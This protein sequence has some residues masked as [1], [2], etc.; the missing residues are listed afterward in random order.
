MILLPTLLLAFPAPALPSAVTAQARVAIVSPLEVA[1]AAVR[2]ESIRS[3]LFFLAS[4]ELEGRDTPSPGLRIAA[5]YIRTR[6]E[7]L[8]WKPGAGGSF[9]HLY[10]LEQR[11][12]DEE[13]SLIAWEAG[14]ERGL[15]RYGTDYFLPSLFDCRTM[16]ARGGVVFCGTGSP[17]DFEGLALEGRWALCF[18]VGT[19]A[20]R[21]REPARKAGAVGVLLA[22]GPGYQGEPYPKRYA[23]DLARQRRGGAAF[24]ADA[25]NRSPERQPYPTVLLDGEVLARLLA[26]AGVF[27]ETAR[28]TDVLGRFDESSFLFLLPGT[29]P[30]GARVMAQRVS[31]LADRRGLEDLV[32]DRVVFSAGI[33]GFPHPAV[34]RRE[35]LLAAARAAFLSARSR[36][37]S[38]VVA[39]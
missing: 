24:P 13:R 38:V 33:A 10:P 35:D 9:L 1:L 20:R 25:R 15:L 31:E 27:L 6:L 36:G 16:E 21:L 11:R 12:L 19:D 39:E 22:P 4:D 17:E 28:D 3:D 18:D 5:R 14:A 32:G 30:D 26:A 29:G 34:R 7:R 8:G 23:A 2:T 37:G